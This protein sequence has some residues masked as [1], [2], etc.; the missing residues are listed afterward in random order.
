[1]AA[2]SF[3]LSGVK[4]QTAFGLLPE[5][6]YPC[7]I[8]DA[9]EVKSRSG[10]GQ[11]AVR[12]EVTASG[13]EGRVVTAWHMTTTDLGKAQ[14]V[15]MIQCAGLDKESFSDTEQ[16]IGRAIGVKTIHR[17]DNS[18]EM[19][20]RVDGYYAVATQPQEAA[21]EAEDGEWDEEVPF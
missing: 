13:H 16:L 1:M 3:S 2:L 8:K 14:I 7:V 4:G 12:Y 18:G 10:N 5:G 17:R 6:E 9:K 15:G 21:P 19:R 11:L 20:V